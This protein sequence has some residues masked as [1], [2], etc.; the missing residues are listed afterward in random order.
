[1]ALTVPGALLGQPPRARHSGTCSLLPGPPLSVAFLLPLATQHADFLVAARPHVR[2]HYPE[3]PS[4][5]PARRGR[6]SAPWDYSSQKSSGEGLPSLT[7]RTTILRAF[8]FPAFFFL[9]APLSRWLGVGGDVRRVAAGPRFHLRPLSL[10]PLGCPV[11]G[12]RSWPE[13]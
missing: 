3:V 4:S 12:R 7:S 6:R 1:M 9:P 5:R 8:C 13:R 10:P 11:A 2:L